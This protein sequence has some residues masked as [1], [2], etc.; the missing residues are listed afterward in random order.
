MSRKLVLVVSFIVALCLFGCGGKPLPVSLSVSA[1]ATTVDGLDSVV[2]TATVTNDRNNDGVT[3][4]ATGSGTF[5]GSSATTAT[6][7]APAA[8][9]SAQ[10]VTVTATSVADKSQTGTATITVPAAPAVT[11]KSTDLTGAVGSAFSVQL[12]GSGG[13]SPY[14]W[15]LAGGTLPACVTLSPAGVITT[16][17][18]TAPAASCAGTFSNLVFKVTDSGTPTPLATN[19]Q[20]MTLTIAAAPAI[21]LSPGG[22]GTVALP[23]G[24]YNTAYQTTITAT[25]GAGAL[26]LTETGPLPA[27]LT[28]S[29]GVVSGKP[30]AG[31][32][33]P[34]SVTATDGYG[35]S[36]TQGYS[37]TVGYPT[38]TITTATLVAGYGGTAYSQTLAVTGGSGAGLSWTVTSG[39]GSLAAI[40]LSLSNAGVL[41]GA[42]PVAGSA[43]F[44][45]KVTDSASDTATATL[46]VTIN[47]GL[48]ITTPATLPAGYGGTAYS[49]TL[50]S[51]GGTGTGLTWS[52]TSGG[53]GLT[54]MGLALSNAGVVSGASPITGTA[55]FGVTVTDSGSNS[56]TA[57][58]SVTINSGLTIT[59][60][61]ILPNGYAG[62]AYLQALAATGGSNTGYSWAVT[63]GG[64]SLTAIG[65]SVSSSG[66]VSGTTPVAG[67]AS[68]GVR[69][70]DSASNTATAALTVTISGGL[71]IT[72][73]STLPGGGVGA[74]YSQ[75]LT[76]TGGSGAGLNWTVVSGGTS[77]TAIGLS[78]SSGGVLSGSSPLAG[79]AT[80]GVKVTDSLSNF[81]TANLS[82]TVSS[83]FTVSGQIRLTGGCVNDPAPPL[84][85]FNVSIDTNPVQNTTTDI[86]GEFSFSNVP[87]GPHNITPSIVGPSAAFYPPSASFT[88]DNADTGV[89]Y[90]TVAL[91]YTVSGSVTYSGPHSGPVYLTLQSANCGGN[92]QYGTS[93]VRAKFDGG[94]QGFA[95]QGV[96][97][98]VYNLYSWLDQ[99]YSGNLVGSGLQNAADPAGSD[100]NVIV[101]TD[102]AASASVVLHDP[103][104]Y[105]PASGPELVAISP[106]DQG[107]VINF[108]PVTAIVN[109]NPV[110]T[111]TV[112]WVEWSTDPAF[113]NT[114]KF[115]A[116]AGARS[117]LWFVNN[118]TV[119]NS[120]KNGSTYYFRA[121]GVGP[122]GQ[123]AYSVYGGSTN[124]TGVTIGAPTAG[125]SI[126][127]NVGFDGAATG[128]L[129]VGFLQR[130]SGMAYAERIESPVSYQDFSVMVP[131]GNNYYMF[132]IMDQYMNGVVDLSDLSNLGE[133]GK[134][135]NMQISYD[136]QEYATLSST[137]APSKLT[138]TF[139]N[140]YDI[141][142]SKTGYRLNFNVREGTSL[143]IAVQLASGPKVPFPVDFAT[144]TTCSAAQ[145]S[146]VVG[147]D[148]KPSFADTYQLNVTYN[149]GSSE[150][151][152]V[153]VTGTQGVF[154]TNLAPMKTNGAITTPSLSW[155]NPAIQYNYTY[156]F[157]LTDAYGNTIWQVPAANAFE[158]AFSFAETHWVGSTNTSTINWG[159]D[160]YNP[161]NKPTI[162]EL[163][164]ASLYYW[165]ITVIDG[166][167]NAAE[168]RAYYAP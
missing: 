146:N 46:S 20:A 113:T 63:S 159:E 66:V 89:P 96:P 100:F 34:F 60:L 79:T 99:T 19:S 136:T 112:Y 76:V 37:L 62:T 33:F 161:S 90:F 134:Y 131:T 83:G 151:Q 56:A 166:N 147:M 50:A 119:P 68:F 8:T 55:T 45:V 40:G 3:W 86:N 73:P 54:A 125:N 10:T 163:S 92:P 39:G 58:F 102:N 94:G 133:N 42:A 75:T 91:G 138:T 144:C 72:S 123:G 168:T 77:L 17:S 71:T 143:P 156:R 48:A 4:T 110:E 165:S 70:T 150:T 103:A 64:S 7:T 2:L 141:S 32:T 116:Q 162:P 44:G 121:Y 30:T 88:V 82:V 107:V 167:G 59:T 41:S 57:T 109:G 126:T 98:G 101:S 115:V 21:V 142:G 124:P 29:N 81:A 15:A 78:L 84:P 12:Q 18:G 118:Q 164:G 80:F 9:S 145:F 106:M 51:S 152:S 16:A 61:T 122:G 67:T 23:A 149:S 154:A 158:D 49:Q 24:T 1:A 139:Y 13:I 31:G 53:S 105:V 27:G 155:T 137:P 128:P 65:L 114:M 160:L 87:N 28:F 97:P 104:L 117:N 93:F 132:A 140:D 108:K 120:F 43:T 153:Q 129:Y 35:D 5:S 148:E 14:K 11:T 135:G 157:K 95:I 85:T 130:D 36:A 38:L 6:Y 111:P 22:G 25:G 69:V 127:G 47:P 26:S 52:V 74:A